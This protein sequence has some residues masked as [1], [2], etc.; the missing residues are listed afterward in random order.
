MKNKIHF[1]LIGCGMIS[2]F[3][4][5]A[6]QAIDGAELSGIYDPYKPAME[7]AAQDYGART[8]DTLEAMLESPEID[9]V[10][11]LTPNGTHAPLA[12]QALWT[13]KHVVV[14]KPMAI[15]KADAELLVQTARETGLQLCV[16][17][18]LRFSP[19][20]QAVRRAVEEGA[21]G[22]IVSASLSMK[23]YRT[24]E[25]YTASNWRGTWEMDGGGALMNQG[26]HGVDLLQY[27]AGPVKRV[28]GIIKT[29]T[30][31]MEAEDSVA[32]VL[33]FENGAIGTLEG[34]TA[35]YP[36]Y[37][38]RLEI[39][40]ERG[41]VV[42]S[43]E[44]ILHWD[45]PEP[46]P[47]LDAHSTASASDPGAIDARGHLRQLKNMVAA[48]R[49]QESLLVDGEAGRKPVELILGIY[50]SARTGMPVSL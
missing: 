14:E 23:Y 25:Y 32:A 38:R 41:S 39:C 17:S 6:L 1:G 18:Q 33:E 30:R 45:L 42:L 49:G 40:G 15:T 9:A 3:H 43:E 31:P 13:G 44:D 35:C 2:K 12:H 7:R 28:R 19:A 47:Q 46:R 48:I 20:I 37:P 10:C 5:Q 34:S 29:Q 4:A 21:F 22:R 8:Y 11:I 50:E 26:I 16:I 27:L 36:G 24:Q